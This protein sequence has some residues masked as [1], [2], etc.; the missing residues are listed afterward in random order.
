MNSS[1]HDFA[2]NLALLSHTQL[3][4]QEKTTVMGNSAGLGLKAHRGKSKV[5]KNNA[6]VRR[7]SITLDENALENVVSFTYSVALLANK[8]E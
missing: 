1:P 7:T 3:Q 8:G 6:A 5:P 4:M 2:D